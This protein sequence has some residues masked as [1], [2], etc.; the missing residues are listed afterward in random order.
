MQT[1]DTEKTSDF[2]SLREEAR[3]RLRERE[4]KESENHICIYIERETKNTKSSI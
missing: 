4:R 3:Q 2:S 1:S